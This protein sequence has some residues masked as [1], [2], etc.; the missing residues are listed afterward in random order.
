MLLQ[1]NDWL[2]H[3]SIF[4]RQRLE[5]ENV[6]QTTQ[7]RLFSVSA[8]GHEFVA[9]VTGP[10]APAPAAVAGLEIARDLVRVRVPAIILKK[11]LSF[12]L[13][14]SLSL[15]LFLSFLSLSFPLLKFCCPKTPL[16]LFCDQFPSGSN[17]LTSF[18][19]K[20]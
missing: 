10:A 2:L 9:C 17:L 16:T 18:T 5:A 4:L 15:S 12:F 8:L 7:G 14:L 19:F 11:Q 20:K 6:L 3:N 13:S 1:S